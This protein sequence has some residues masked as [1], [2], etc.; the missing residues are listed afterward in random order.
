MKHLALF[1]L[2]G[3]LILSA[4]QPATSIATATLTLTPTE[5][6]AP[7]QTS[8]PIPTIEPTPTLEAIEGGWST[9]HTQEYGFRFLYPAV[10][11]KGF[12]DP[13]DPLTFCK[14]QT[15]KE[16]GNFNIWVGF[17]AVAVSEISQSLE[18]VSSDYVKDKSVDWDILSRTQSRIDS[19]P[20]VTVEYGHQNPDR[21]GFKTFLIYGNDLITI[22]Y[23][24]A[25]FASC[26]PLGTQYS[27]YWVYQQI[28]NTLRFDQ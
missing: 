5:T 21:W 9:F 3:V 19:V 16:D 13:A 14:I 2:T 20:A 25:P 7:T 26:S 6:A 28:L 22:D 17:V 18:E 27:S 15:K 24:E 11:D 12:Y 10:Y 4:C 8:A 23:Y 1:I